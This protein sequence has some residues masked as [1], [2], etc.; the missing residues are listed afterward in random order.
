[1]NPVDR[2]RSFEKNFVKYTVI[3][4]I[5]SLMLG[6]G[7]YGKF[8]AEGNAFHPLLNDS[9]V[10]ISL[11]VIGAIVMTWGGMNVLSLL[12]EKAKLKKS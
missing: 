1:M 6:L 11:L 4:A 8:G 2:T 5:G 9:A 10:V 3:D 12:K 7:L